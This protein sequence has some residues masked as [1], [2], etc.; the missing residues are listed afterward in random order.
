MNLSFFSPLPGGESPTHDLQK[1]SGL[2]LRD[3]LFFLFPPPSFF[4][5]ICQVC[6]HDSRRKNASSSAQ[7]LSVSPF[8]PFFLRFLKEVGTRVHD[9]WNVCPFPPSL[10]FSSFLWRLLEDSVVL[11]KISARRNLKGIHLSSRPFSPSLSLGKHRRGVEHASFPFLRSN[12]D[13]G[14]GA[15]SF[16]FKSSAFLQRDIPLRPLSPRYP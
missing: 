5:H 8:P 6:R 16:F 4:L 3:L 11:T 7:T 9:D 13:L 1:R 15:F 10:L 12:S 2:L 14:R